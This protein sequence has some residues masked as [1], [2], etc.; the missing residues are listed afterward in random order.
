MPKTTA[1]RAAR[2]T[3]CESSNELPPLFMSPCN[4]YV[5]VAVG[6]ELILSRGAAARLGLELLHAATHDAVVKDPATLVELNERLHLLC[7]RVRTLAALL[8][9]PLT[10]EI[11][12]Q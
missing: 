4:Q 11:V 9:M 1:R 5:A 7:Q 6:P 3:V 10:D 12:L 8:C 2:G